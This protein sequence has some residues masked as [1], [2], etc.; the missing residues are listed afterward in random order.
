MKKVVIKIINFFF[1]KKKEMT[2]EEFKKIT[3]YPDF[4]DISVKEENKENF[5]SLFLKN[6]CSLLDIDDY[7]DS[8]HNSDSD[9]T[10][11]D[12]LGMSSEDYKLFIKTPE[13]LN[14]KYGK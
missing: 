6:K 4:P 5:F 8:W 11:K 2:I 1:K 14:E 7:I 12:F 10:L 13:K 9:L 3:N